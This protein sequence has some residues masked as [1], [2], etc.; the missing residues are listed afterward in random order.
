MYVCGIIV[1]DFCYIGYGCMFVV[2]DVVVCYLCFFGY[3]LKY[4]CN[5]IDIDDK[6]IKCVNENGESFV[7]LVDRMIVEMYQDFDVLNILCLDSELCVMYYIQEIIEFICILIEKGYVYVVDNG[8]VMFD[9]L[10]DL[11]Y[12]QFFCQDFEQFQVGVCVDVVDVKCNLMDFVLWKMLKEGELSWLLLWGEGCLGWYIEC[13]VMNCKQLGNYF[14][15]YGGGFDLMFL[16]YEN[17][18]VQFIC[19]YD[20]EYVNYWMYFGMVMVDCEKMFKLLGNF[21]IVC[22]VLKYY[23]VEIVCYFLMFGYYC[24]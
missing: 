23:D 24:S 22:D 19:V 13:L 9:V 21:F 6:I 20:G 4:V 14:D 5:I 8:D 7:V 16:Y 2:F 15:I 11:I 10:I 18:I 1:Y 12:G 3:K 17:E